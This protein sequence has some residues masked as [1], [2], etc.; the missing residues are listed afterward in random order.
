M[1]HGILR[2]L[3]VLA[4]RIVVTLWNG[5]SAHIRNAPG[6]IEMTFLKVW[7]TGTNTWMLTGL[8]GRIHVVLMFGC[9]RVY[10]V[11]TTVDFFAIM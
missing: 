8:D 9:S 5:G 7:K 11:S 3:V 10:S 1:V 4:T 6:N 2:F